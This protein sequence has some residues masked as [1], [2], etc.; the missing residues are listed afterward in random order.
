LEGLGGRSFKIWPSQPLVGV[1]GNTFYIVKKQIFIHKQCVC[2]LTYSL[3]R[4]VNECF[5]SNAETYFQRQ[6][7]SQIDHDNLMWQELTSKR[8]SCNRS[9]NL[10]WKLR[11][12]VLHIQE[13]VL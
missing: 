1:D 12:R 11:A 9:V 10:D 5:K 8:C 6:C 7:F 13:K 2:I 4:Q 3:K